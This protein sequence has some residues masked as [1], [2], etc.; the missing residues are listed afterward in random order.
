VDIRKV[1]KLMEMLEESSLS[2]LE[3]IEGEESIRLSKATNVLSQNEVNQFPVA[4]N[5]IN[6]QINSDVKE[7]IVAPLEVTGHEI[8]SPMVGTFYSRPNPESDAFVEAG[9]SVG[10][11][12]VI[13][14]LEAMK[15]FNEIHAEFR[16]TIIEVLAAEGE[17]VEFGQNLFKYKA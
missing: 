2:E 17:T 3:I 6:P 16:G 4:H 11:D 14:I 15:V 10:V 9:D 13:C 1:K 12:D 7:T 8:K 5:P